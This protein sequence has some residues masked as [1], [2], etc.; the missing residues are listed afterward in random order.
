[1]PKAVAVEKLRCGDVH[2]VFSDSEAKAATLRNDQEVCRQT[3]CRIFREDFPV[4]AQAVALKAVQLECSRSADNKQVIQE[5]IKANKGN[6]PGL[7][8]TRIDW[9]HG[10]KS[11]TQRKDVKRS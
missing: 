7:E 11:L 10:S 9:I 2:V 1:M 5:I 3:R 4:E 6:N 8:I